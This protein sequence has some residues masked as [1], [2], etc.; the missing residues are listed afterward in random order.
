MTGSTGI[1]I[2][3]LQNCASATLFGLPVL[4]IELLAHTPTHVVCC[5]WKSSCCGVERKLDLCNAV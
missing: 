2:S 4:G 3:Y 1:D 5:T